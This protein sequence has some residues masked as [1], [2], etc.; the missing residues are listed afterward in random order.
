[1]QRR[2]TLLSEMA[3]WISLKTDFGKEVRVH[4]WVSESLALDMKGLLRRTKM[5]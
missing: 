4:F 2:R 3:G 5:M 1:V